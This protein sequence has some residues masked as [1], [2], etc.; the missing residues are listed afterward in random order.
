VGRSGVFNHQKDCG[1]G[2]KHQP[3]YNKLQFEFGDTVIEAVAEAA[4][5][6]EDGITFEF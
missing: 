2:Y 4:L 3:F 6:E 5:S 1:F